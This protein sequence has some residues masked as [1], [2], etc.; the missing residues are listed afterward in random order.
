MIQT[1]FGLCHLFNRRKL[2]KNLMIKYQ[3]F[4]ETLIVLILIQ[5]N[6]QKQQ[7]LL[8]KELKCVQIKSSYKMRYQTLWSFQTKLTESIDQ[9]HK[10]TNYTQNV[11][12]YIKYCLN[13]AL[14]T[15]TNIMQKQ[16]RFQEFQKKAYYNKKQLYL[17]LNFQGIIC[18][19]QHILI[20]SIQSSQHTHFFV[21]I[22]VSRISNSYSIVYLT[23]DLTFLASSLQKVNIK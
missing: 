20:L 3:Y 5:Y 2:K 14:I 6:T 7:N 1:F 10:F 8:L 9:F 15:F 21:Q 13:D 12:Y 18:L 22:I 17:I 19:F 4:V 16:K 23:V 11:N